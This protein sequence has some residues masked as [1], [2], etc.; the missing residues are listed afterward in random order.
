[1]V[2][3]L[4]S[5]SGFHY[6]L[7]ILYRNCNGSLSYNEG[8]TQP[9]TIPMTVSAF[10]KNVGLFHTCHGMSCVAAIEADDFRCGSFGCR[11][12]L[13]GGCLWSLPL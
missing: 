7:T 6:S 1:M 2:N 13:L 9:N 5:V 4:K 12:F 3:Y 8:A 11:T 10:G